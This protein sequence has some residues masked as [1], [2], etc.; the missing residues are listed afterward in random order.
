MA[1]SPLDRLYDMLTERVGFTRI[2]DV[3]LE[4]IAADRALE[5]RH[6]Q[7]LIYNNSNPILHQ[8]NQLRA[9]VYPWQDADGTTEN[10]TW[11]YYPP[12][13]VDPIDAAVDWTFPDEPQYGDLAGDSI[14]W[15]NS[16]VHRSQLEDTRWTHWGHGIYYEDTGLGARRWYFITVF[17]APM[18]DLTASNITM[19]PGKYIGFDF[20]A[21]GKVIQKHYRTLATDTPAAFDE[22]MHV[23]GYGP[24]FHM[25]SKP[26]R[27]RW[28][29]DDS[30][31]SWV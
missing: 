4:K 9:R 29:K 20:T 25:A 18:K 21:D 5:M 19:A 22:R 13:W 2:R 27:N 8:M 11:H 7:G 31:I 3:R 23:P 6:H 30:K 26:M 12:T 28:V 16:T 14:G 10:A 1:V 15:W 17:A 24:M